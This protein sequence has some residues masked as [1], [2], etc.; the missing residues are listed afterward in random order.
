MYF[1]TF[2]LVMIVTVGVIAFGASLVARTLNVIVRSMFK[3]RPV[4]VV[5][6]NASPLSGDVIEPERSK[7]NPP[8]GFI[9]GRIIDGEVIRPA[10][11]C[12][13]SLAGPR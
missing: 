13:K 4:R 3:A 1:S 6:Q 2:V 10:L 5:S 12:N 8:V 11:H 9:T 7:Q